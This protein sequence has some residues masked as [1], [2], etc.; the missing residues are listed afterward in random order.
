MQHADNNYRQINPDRLLDRWDITSWLT[1]PPEGLAAA[2]ER[3]MVAAFLAQGNYQAN[4]GGQ[5]TRDG[6][7]VP[8]NDLLIDIQLTAADL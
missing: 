4:F 2:L 7:G 6:E 1:A 3:A 8:K 5:F